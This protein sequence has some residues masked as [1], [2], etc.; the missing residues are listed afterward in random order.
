MAIYEPH[1]YA[2]A[3]EKLI[4]EFKIDFPDNINSKNIKGIAQALE[5]GKMNEMLQNPDTMKKILKSRPYVKSLKE[6]DI[7]LHE[8]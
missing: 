4:K 3:K 5:V 8:V 6:F 1:C 2:C 7:S